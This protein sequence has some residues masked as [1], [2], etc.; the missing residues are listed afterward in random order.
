MFRHKLKALYFPIII[1]VSFVAIFCFGKFSNAQNL[2]LLS[3]D[4]KRNN[5][6]FCD[7]HSHPSNLEM[8]AKEMVMER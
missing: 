7:L 3:V 4:F 8:V 2:A 5:F 6:K 1:I